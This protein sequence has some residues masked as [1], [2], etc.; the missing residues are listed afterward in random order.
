MQERAQTRKAGAAINL[1]RDSDERWAARLGGREDEGTEAVAFARR[2]LDPGD[3]E[4]RRRRR[5]A[6]RQQAR[7]LLQGPANRT[8]MVDHR[9]LLAGMGHR[10][11][12]L[13][14]GVVSPDRGGLGRHR[15]IL[16]ACRLG[17]RQEGQKKLQ[18]ESE[19]SAEAAEPAQEPR[20]CPV[21]GYARMLAPLT[22]ENRPNG[23]GPLL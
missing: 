21:P 2:G 11:P 23:K 17:H 5:C 6:G 3:D 14:E 7:G 1:R 16:R 9:A 15:R 18:G 8:L 13:A 10:H 12:G 22:H 4:K 20:S 19:D